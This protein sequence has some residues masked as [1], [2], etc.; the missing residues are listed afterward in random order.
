MTAVKMGEQAKNS[1]EL[2]YGSSSAKAAEAMERALCSMTRDVRKVMILHPVA[3]F[4]FQLVLLSREFELFREQAEGFLLVHPL[5]VPQL[6]HADL[7]LRFE[8]ESG[9][10]TFRDGHIKHVAGG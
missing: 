2:K 9:K 3:R 1:P 6:Q 4:R 5:V 10:R 8:L 7:E